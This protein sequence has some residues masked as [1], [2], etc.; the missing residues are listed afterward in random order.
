[1]VGRSC[2]SVHS[3]AERKQTNPIVEAVASVKL[4]CFS[5]QWKWKE[6]KS[7]VVINLLWTLGIS[8]NRHVH[9]TYAQWQAHWE[10]LSPLQ[11]L[12]FRSRLFT[13]MFC[14]WKKSSTIV[15]SQCQKE[16]VFLVDLPDGKPRKHLQPVAQSLWHIS[17]S[18]KGQ[19]NVSLK[20]CNICLWIVVFQATVHWVWWRAFWF[21]QTE[22][23]WK[24][25]L[26]TAP[27]PVITGSGNKEKKLPPTPSVTF[28]T[29]RTPRRFYFQTEFDL[30]LLEVLQWNQHSKAFGHIGLA[31][32]TDA[33]L[34]S[35][36]L[37]EATFLV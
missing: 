6:P 35:V 9:A 26:L 33:L 34:E 31:A 18:F 22:K 36:Y 5:R 4:I 17:S 12:H 8:G 25:K 27:S 13:Q 20:I 10:N 23:R 2:E 7:G 30:S 28:L 1:M 21:V 32:I 15:G 24:P 29:Y 37:F 14:D 16:N 19:T 3:W 11:L